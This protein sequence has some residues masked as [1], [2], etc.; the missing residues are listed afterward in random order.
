MQKPSIKNRSGD[1]IYTR[2]ITCDKLRDRYE[3]IF[4]QYDYIWLPFNVIY[5][6]PIYQ[7]IAGK[8]GKDKILLTPHSCYNKELDLNDFFQW[9]KDKEFYNKVTSN[10]TLVFDNPPFSLGSK[11]IKNLTQ[12]N[13]D[14]ILFGNTMS[15]LDKLKTLGCLYHILGQVPFDNTEDD[16][17]IAISLFSNLFEEIKYQFDCGGEDRRDLYGFFNEDGSPSWSNRCNIQKY[18]D[19]DGLIGS[20]EVINVCARGY[21]FHKNKIIACDKTTHCFGGGMKYQFE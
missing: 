4:S 18:I 7:S 17:R 12:N 3:Y 15:A 16:K 11:I 10:K 14:Y 2:K 9:K 20:A 8:Y 13:V 21:V 19:K 5:E 6:T 1:E